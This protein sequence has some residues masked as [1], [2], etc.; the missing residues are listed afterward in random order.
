MNILKRDIIKSLLLV[1][2][3]SELL[4]ALL[5]VVGCDV[6]VKNDEKSSDYAIAY[7][8]DADGDTFGDPTN[9]VMAMSQPEGYV[10]N[11]SDCDDTD[12]GINPGATEICGDG[13]DQ[14]CNG[15]ADDPC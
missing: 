6:S 3:L 1:S 5:L 9:S 12:A 11:S 4:I 14:N 2:F 13:I 15:L 8:R 10:T 7:Y